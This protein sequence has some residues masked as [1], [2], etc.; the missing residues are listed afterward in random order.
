MLRFA[1]GLQL[2]NKYK[3]SSF[4]LAVTAGMAAVFF[5]YLL[6]RAALPKMAAVALSTTKSDIAQ[7]LYAIVMAIGVF[8]L[9]VFVFI[10][11][12]TFGDD[13]NARYRDLH[14]Q[15][16]EVT[17][18]ME[19]NPGRAELYF[20][21]AELNRVHGLWDA[22]E[23]DYD[24]TVSLDPKLLMVDLGRGK[25]FLEA[26]WPLSSRAVL[27]RYLNH[28]TNE[29]EGLVTRARVLTK[30]EQREAAA[31]DY[32]FALAQIN[33][34]RPELYLERA[35]VLTGGDS[36]RF[37]EALRGLEEGI[38][39]MGPLVTLQ[40]YALDLELK[41]QH[42]DAALARLDKIMAQFPRKETWLARRGEILQQ[43]G[44]P[45]EAREAYRAALN[46]MDTLPPARRQVPAMVELQKKLHRALDSIR[47]DETEVKK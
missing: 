39:K 29:A 43:A 37:E 41:Q 31:R 33:D 24:R 11:G 44:R 20:K 2:A 14:A 34:P 22:A 18:Q 47:S 13:I 35:Q 3:N 10:P 45:G 19:Q 21:R 46:A 6:Q 5:A 4:M 38:Q 8:A 30:L 9:L 36:A 1:T 17:R 26:G 27:D 40:I 42:F 32:S 25:M 16:L 15:I 23:A 28:Q 7:P 12:N